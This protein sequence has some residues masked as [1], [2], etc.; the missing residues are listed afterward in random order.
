MS[1]STS[2]PD[3]DAEAPIGAFDVELPHQGKCSLCSCSD[4]RGNDTASGTGPER[5]HA[6]TEPLSFMVARISTI[7]DKRVQ[8]AASSASSGAC[9]RLPFS[10]LQAFQAAKDDAVARKRFSAVAARSRR[11]KGLSVCPFGV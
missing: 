5:D 1:M 10:S 4:V 11:A 8:A 2:S 3:I 6:A 9:S 7:H